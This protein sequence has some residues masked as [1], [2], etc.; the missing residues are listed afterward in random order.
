MSAAGVRSSC[1]ASATKRSWASKLARIGASARRVTRRVTR[2]APT[3]PTSPTTVIASTRLADWASWRVRTKPAWTKPAGLLAE[4]I[5][6][7]RRRTATPPR[8]TVRRSPPAAT[9]PA[10]ASGTG[11][12]G[13]VTREGSATTPPVGSR[14]STNV[15]E[16]PG[17]TSSESDSSWVAGSSPPSRATAASAA[18]RSDR[19]TSASSA[20]RAASAVVTPIPTTSRATRVRLVR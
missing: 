12:P 2:P 14:Y 11:S 9:A 4:P 10:R 7:V 3:S 15:S 16:E 5:D 1:E 19:S 8:C 17:A 18:P 13:R 20:P 6:R